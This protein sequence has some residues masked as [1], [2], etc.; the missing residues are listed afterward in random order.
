MASVGFL[1]SARSPAGVTMWP[2][3]PVHSGLNMARNFI[4]TVKEQGPGEP[5]FIQLEMYEN[6]GMRNKNILL[7]LPDGTDID[8]AKRISVIL[9]SE[10]ESLRLLRNG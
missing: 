1:A 5:C 6:I 3:R 10:I 9:N 8:D 7:C 4:A 2:Q